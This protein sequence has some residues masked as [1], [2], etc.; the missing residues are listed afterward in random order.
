VDIRDTWLRR[1]LARALQSRSGIGKY[2]DFASFLVQRITAVVSHCTLSV[3]HNA[4]GMLNVGRSPN[5]REESRRSEQ[6][7]RVQRE[8]RSHKQ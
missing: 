7:S 5:L 4:N 1:E 8:W 2:T 3:D 6:C